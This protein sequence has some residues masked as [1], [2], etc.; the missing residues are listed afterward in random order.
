M[1]FRVFGGGGGG[2]PSCFTG[3]GGV[4]CKMQSS[5]YSL[6]TITV[7]S[8]WAGQMSTSEEDQPWSGS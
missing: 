1:D 5:H 6:I 4:C 7:V 3:R 2:L 8:E